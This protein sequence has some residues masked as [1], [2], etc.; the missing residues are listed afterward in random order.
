MSR[1]LTLSHHRLERTPPGD[2]YPARHRPGVVG[3]HRRVPVPQART[4]PRRGAGG[5]LRLHRRGQPAPMPRSSRPSRSATTGTSLTTSN[6]S[7]CRPRS[8]GGVEG[9]TVCHFPEGVRALYPEDEILREFQ[10]EAFIGHPLPDAAGRVPGLLAI[11]HTKP[12]ANPGQVQSILQISAARAA[13]ELERDYSG[14][15][16]AQARERHRA[17]RRFGGHHRPRGRRDQC[18]QPGYV[19]TTGIPAYERDTRGYRREGPSRA[20]WFGQEKPTTRKKPSGE[21]DA[22]F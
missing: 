2:G 4:Q 8:A 18:R 12:L 14:R 11:M 20:D 1:G 22:A 5:G 21:H 19:K 15:R 3:Q 9:K 10:V 6:T 17:D 7:S 16:V 13:A